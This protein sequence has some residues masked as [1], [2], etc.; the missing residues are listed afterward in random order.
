VVD[1]V[2][3]AFGKVVFWGSAGSAP[4]PV[5]IDITIHHAVQIESLREVTGKGSCW[6]GV[7]GTVMDDSGELL[8]WD[9]CWWGVMGP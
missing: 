2:V 3:M 1:E 5:P 4:K 7:P 8:L 6:I 9:L